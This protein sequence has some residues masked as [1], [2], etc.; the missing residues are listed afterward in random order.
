MDNIEN[1]YHKKYLK[2]KMK[3]YNL[4]QNGGFL[5]ILAR[6]VS[7][8]IA[9]EIAISAITTALTT[10]NTNTNNTNKNTHNTNIHKPIK[11]TI[12]EK[13]VAIC[14]KKTNN[15]FICT[16]SNVSRIIKNIPQQELEKLCN[17]IAT[18]IGIPKDQCM[19]LIN[20]IK[21]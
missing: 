1:K 4:K 14:N 9:R 6:V 10:N 21:K 19:Q 12:L 15:K 7:S 17:I 5:P 2:Y 11:E 3:Y 8:P 13:I 18:N 16:K 20:E